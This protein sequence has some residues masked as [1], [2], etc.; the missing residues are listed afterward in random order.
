MQRYLFLQYLEP[1]TL[2]V[3][4]SWENSGCN[5]L[6]MPKGFL[7]SRSIRNQVEFSQSYL[8]KTCCVSWT[9]QHE[10]N[11]SVL[12]RK[13][14]KRVQKTIQHYDLYCEIKG[15]DLYYDDCILMFFCKFASSLGKIAI[16]KYFLYQT[17]RIIFQLK[18]Q[19]MRT[20]DL[21][22]IWLRAQVIGTS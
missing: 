21:G 19:L 22:K 17:S 1:K 13:D 3:T 16:Q 11:S 9:V 6:L 2:W 8:K 5:T 7:C 18:G 12:T 4:L 10:I 15:K 14:G 20:C